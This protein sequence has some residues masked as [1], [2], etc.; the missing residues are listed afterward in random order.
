MS[1]ECLTLRSQILS[2]V[3][4]D[5]STLRRL[6]NFSYS[7]RFTD[8]CIVCLCLVVFVPERRLGIGE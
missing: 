6:L 4:V 1:V 2:M 8:S 3:F 5:P 7:V